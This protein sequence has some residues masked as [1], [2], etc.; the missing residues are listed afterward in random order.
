MATFSRT[1]YIQNIQGLLPDN[2]TQQISPLDLRTS[3]VDIVDS[4]H[5]FF[6]DKDI[7]SNNFSTPDVRS[8][9]GGRG[10]IASINLAGRSSTD[11]SAFGYQTLRQNYDG[12]GNTAVGSFSQGCNLYGDSNTSIGYLAL[13]SNT[14][15]DGNVAVGSYALNNNKRGNFN[16]AIGHGAGWYI[17]PDDDYTLSIGSFNVQSED[18]CDV[19]GDLLYTS[20]DKPLIYGNLDPNNHKLA[21]ATD[22][23]HEYGTLQVS[24]DVSPT[25]PNTF[26][27]GKS[28]YPWLGINDEIY[29]SG[30]YV[31]VGGYPSGAAHGILGSAGSDDAKMTV[32]GDLIPSESGR[33]ALGHPS[34]P[35]DGYFNDV[36]ISGQLHANDVNYN[37]VN[38]CLYDCKTLHL[39]TSGFCDPEDDG[40]H[41]SAVCGF[42]SDSDLDGAGFEIHSSGGSPGQPDFYRRDYRFI[43]RQPD[44]TLKCLPFGD[45]F[46]RSRFESN[47]SLEIESGKALITERV[48]GR[49]ETSHITQSGCYGMF[50]NP[51]TVSGQEVRFTDIDQA[52]VQYSGIQ[53]INFI[54]RSGTDLNSCGSPSGYNY[55]VTYGSVDSGVKIIQS[56]LTRIKD[57]NVRGFR[58]IYHDERDSNGELSCDCL[59]NKT[60]DV[61][62]QK[63]VVEPVF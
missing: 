33:Y 32:Y 52:F 10:A 30:K 16:I 51:V 34:L 25:L 5:L 26:W 41:N 4:V 53:D 61:G 17:G 12:S 62:Q 45:A 46:G 21:I 6:A 63:V 57:E 60:L 15:G 20:V 2:S 22:H 8:T 44:A 14:N 23:L 39:A 9:R 54:S 3:L 31:G 24:G 7:V 37:H 58:L 18:F 48:L 50:I 42:L 47:I 36:V 38:E 35:W 19:G 43:Y 49:D 40:F 11:N 59:G 13:A 55:G 28:Q 56:F 27:L 29:F 1:E